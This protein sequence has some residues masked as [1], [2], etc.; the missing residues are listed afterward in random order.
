[1]FCAS[2]SIAPSSRRPWVSNRRQT[3]ACAPLTAQCSAVFA[4]SSAKLADT[5]AISSEFTSGR[6]PA[7]AASRSNAPAPDSVGWRIFAASYHTGCGS[8]S[9]TMKPLVSSPLTIVPNVHAAMSSRK[10]RIDEPHEVRLLLFSGLARRI[11]MITPSAFI[12]DL[13]I[14]WRSSAMRGG[15]GGTAPRCSSSI[16]AC[17]GGEAAR[18]RV[19]ACPAVRLT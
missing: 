9:L 19:A 7:R 1:M 14:A 5:F 3:V 12:A 16:A 8:C 13:L 4:W 18:V 10:A 11:E 15:H 6:L 2:A 17:A